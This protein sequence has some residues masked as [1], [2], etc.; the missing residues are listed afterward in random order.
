MRYLGNKTKLLPFIEQIIEKYQIKGRT[1]ADLFAGT[2][3]VGDNFKDQYKIISNDFL[4]YSFVFN[5]AKL[6]NASM[7]EFK[8]FTNKYN[9]DIFQWLNEQSYQPTKDYFLYQ[10]Y[11]PIGDRM[12]FTAE[13][14]IKIDGIRIKIES[15]KDSHLLTKNE[16]FFLLAS[17]LESVTKVSNTSGTYDAY[18]KFWENRATKQFILKPLS[19]KQTNKLYAIND[20][21]Q[22]DT[23]E[24]I[25]NIKG[26]IA[27]LDPP[28]TNLQY[29]SSYH[30]LETLARYDAPEIK[31]IAG[32]RIANQNKSLYAKKSSVADQFTDLFEHLQFKYIITSYSSQGLLSLDELISLAKPYA[33]QHKVNI[34]HRKYI[35][36]QTH[37]A[38]QKQNG[39]QLNEALI[40]FEKK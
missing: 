13:N 11:S 39:Q 2:G 10:H 36:Y 4:Y 21:Y 38:N 1:F 37:Y 24:L 15:L 22:T 23:N 32:K 40:I 3:A 18:F 20:V 6:T 12:F 31:G 16:Y 26:D 9:K 34:E 33:N 8:C 29:A 7:P 17:L 27:Y 28:Y 5:Q 35:K 25:R 30:I 14:A 19:M